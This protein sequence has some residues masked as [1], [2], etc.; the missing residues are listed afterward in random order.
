M[1]GHVLILILN[2]C[3]PVGFCLLFSLNFL[4]L[5]F[6]VSISLDKTWCSHQHYIHKGAQEIDLEKQSVRAAELKCIAGPHF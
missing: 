6:P 5:Y 3:I 2:F 4:L 1:V